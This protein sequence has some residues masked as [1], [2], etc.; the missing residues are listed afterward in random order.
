MK[1]K[2]L[3][4]ILFR[5]TLSETFCFS[6]STPEMYAETFEDAEKR[7]LTSGF[8]KSGDIALNKADFIE[9]EVGDDEP[10]T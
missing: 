2:K 1:T 5:E 7:F 6:G 10:T 4:R 3:Y 9:V 8:Y